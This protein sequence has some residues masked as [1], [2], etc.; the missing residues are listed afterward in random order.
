MS[1]QR[2]RMKGVITTPR[3]SSLS[4]QNQKESDLSHLG[5]LLYFYMLRSHYDKTNIKGTT[6]HGA[7]VRRQ[8]PVGRRWLPPK[9]IEN[10]H[11]GGKIFL[12][13]S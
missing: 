1:L 7:R 6:L 3:D 12:V 11:F 10:C 2:S 4:P 13:W 9:K 5:D 8:R